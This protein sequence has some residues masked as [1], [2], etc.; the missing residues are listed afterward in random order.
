MLST[1]SSR[2]PLGIA[3]AVIVAVVLG[4]LFIS[5]DNGQSGVG[6]VPATPAPSESPATLLENAMAA[7]CP[8]I[9][10]ELSCLEPGTYQLGDT[11]LWPA[12]VT[13]DVPEN[14][15][16]YENAT[17][18]AGVLV[19]TEDTANGS[20]WGVLFNTVGEVLRDPCDRTA[21]TFAADE[22]DTASEFAAAMAAWPGFEATAPAPI[23]DAAYPGVA[24]TLMSAPR[25]EVCPGGL[26]FTTASSASIDAYPM[27]NE[28]NRPHATEFRIFETEDGLL[29][30]L[31]MNFP[32][33]SPFEEDNGV[34]FDPERHVEHQVEMDAILD[35]I[36]LKDP[37]DGAE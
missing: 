22:V 35:S 4:A 2:A 1:I 7:S 5:R 31:A 10:D 24:I 16:Y 30:V 23:M 6:G 18:S 19:Q 28:Q 21:G 33:P 12:I 29:V 37:D 3:A 17:G 13:F 14:W 11:D 32:E 34:Q 9:T 27:V 25:H 26:L 8:G 36:R 15:W 20:G